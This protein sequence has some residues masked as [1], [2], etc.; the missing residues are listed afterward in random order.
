MG[1]RFNYNALPV[2]GFDMNSPRMQREILMRNPRPGIPP[3]QLVYGVCHWPITPQNN[4]LQVHEA[5]KAA[6]LS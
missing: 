1:P 2:N 5:G 3:V 6:A 4:W